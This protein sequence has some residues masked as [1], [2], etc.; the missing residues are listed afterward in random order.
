MPVAVTK[1]TVSM[2]FAQ[3]MI[4]RALAHARELGKDV[5][6]AVVDDG[7]YLVAFTR[8]DGANPA[9]VKIAMDKAFTAATSRVATHEWTEI[10]KNDEPLRMGVVG[11]VERMIVYGGGQPIV[12]DG[13]VIGA[14]GSSGAHWSGDREITSKA[15]ELLE[16]EADA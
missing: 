4:E 12:L 13:Q 3:R 6:L 11:A 1:Q 8:M 5:S 16:R 2:E 14:I 10:L 9:S 7:G 15:L